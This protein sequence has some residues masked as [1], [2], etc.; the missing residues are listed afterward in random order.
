MTS[1][2]TLSRR[3][4]GLSRRKS[5]SV[6]APHVLHSHSNKLFIYN[7]LHEQLVAHPRTISTIISGNTPDSF[8]PLGAQRA[9][10]HGRARAVRFT[11]QVTKALPG[12]NGK[13]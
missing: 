11:P 9:D 5:N 12:G 2:S 13:S 8:G 6:L 10:L 4:D 7:M 1:S 3:K